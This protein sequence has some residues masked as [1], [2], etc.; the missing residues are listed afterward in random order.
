MKQSE[1]EV[2]RQKIF[3]YLDMPNGYGNQFTG[4][5]R[6]PL[7][8]F[9]KENHIARHIF[10]E[11]KA[12][13]SLGVQQAVEEKNK[14]DIEADKWRR[15]VRAVGKLETMKDGELAEVNHVLDQLY[16]QCVIGKNWNACRE[17][18]KATGNYIEKSEQKVSVI[19]FS[20]DDYLKA[21]T[22]AQQRVDEYLKELR[23]GEDTGNG[24]VCGKSPLLPVEVCLHPEQEHGEGS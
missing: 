14:E 2:Q 12:L 15:K 20:A 16:D 19:E 10:Y 5:K 6:L 3:D 23:Q 13:H 1:K 22:E 21:R 9:L 11:I 4:M 7:K 18:L 24:S 8:V 17:Y